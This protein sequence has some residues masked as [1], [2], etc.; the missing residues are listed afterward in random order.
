MNR[1]D[2]VGVFEVVSRPPSLGYV[3]R[4][5]RMNNVRLIK[6]IPKKRLSLVSGDPT[7][8]PVIGD[9]GESDHCYSTQGGPM[10]LVLFRTADGATEW[11]AEA[12]WNELEASIATEVDM[13]ALF[14]ANAL[15]QSGN[16]PW[17]FFAYP[18]KVAR[19]NGL[20]PDG[21]I[22]MLIAE[23]QKR[24]LPLTIWVNARDEGTSYIACRVHDRSRLEQAI[25]DLEDSGVLEESFLTDRSTQLFAWAGSST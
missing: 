4:Y 18:T 15:Y 5:V 17:T 13:D 23:L 19:K 1:S 10:V 21:D 16:S 7:R 24:G 9:L 3:R 11:E 14:D 6:E 25:A 2:G 22:E 20:P 8:F 12:Y